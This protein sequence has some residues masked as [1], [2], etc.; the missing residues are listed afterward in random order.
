LRHVATLERLASD[1]RLLDRRAEHLMLVTR[2]TTGL[3]VGQLRT[4]KASRTLLCAPVFAVKWRVLGLCV[5]RALGSARVAPA[6]AIDGLPEAKPK[7]SS[8]AA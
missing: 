5:S 3:A 1:R 2:A 7:S 6:A 8:V 4:A